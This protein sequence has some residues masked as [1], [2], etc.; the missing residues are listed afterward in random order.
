MFNNGDC[1]QFRLHKRKAG[2]RVD[3]CGVNVRLNR[4]VYFAQ[5]RYLFFGIPFTTWMDDTDSSVYPRTFDKVEDAPPRFRGI[6][7]E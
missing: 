5:Y 1:V 6:V 2:S 4:E 3:V 7:C